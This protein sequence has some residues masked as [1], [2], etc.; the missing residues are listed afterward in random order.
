MDQ[1]K[2]GNVLKLIIS[3]LIALIIGLPIIIYLIVGIIKFYILVF[4][5]LKN[6]HILFFI[7]TKNYVIELKDIIY[8]SVT[9]VGVGVTGIFSYYIWKANKASAD[10]SEKLGNLEEQRDI[11]IRKENAIILFYSSLSGLEFAYDRFRGEKNLKPAYLSDDWTKNLASIN[12]SF[13]SEEIRIFYQFYSQLLEIKKMESKDINTQVNKFIESVSD[14]SCL[15]YCSL[16]FENEKVQFISPLAILNLKYR[17]LFI[18][19]ERL[20]VENKIENN[21]VFNERDLLFLKGTFDNNKFI[22]GERYEYYS[23]GNIFCTITYENEVVVKK[24][25]MNF[26]GNEILENCTYINGKA[27]GYKRIYKE[28]GKRDFEGEIKNGKKYNG[29]GFNFL[30]R[31]SDGYDYYS[32]EAY[33]QYIEENTQAYEESIDESNC[34]KWVEFCQV[35]FTDGEYI[36]LE[37]TAYTEFQY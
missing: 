6:N 17:N 34:D 27:S 26:K 11:I 16:E 21:S 29:T 37:E 13:S 25:L 32:E 1:K 22:S 23:N 19:L 20:F 8:F 10:V 14:E 4:S 7:D 28:N 9:L 15:E 5:Y 18:K 2:K 12:S 24:Q 31:D 30:L 36:I 35:K 3:I 33:R